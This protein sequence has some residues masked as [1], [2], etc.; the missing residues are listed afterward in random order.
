MGKVPK[1]AFLLGF[2]NV[3]VAVIPD[4]VAVRNTRICIQPPPRNLSLR[5]NQ[6]NGN[7]RAGTAATALL[8]L[9]S[10]FSKTHIFGKAIS[11]AIESDRP[12]GNLS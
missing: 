2:G 3:L 5:Q 11:V 1:L 6:Q 8:F 7:T 4:M 12:W 9:I 10:I